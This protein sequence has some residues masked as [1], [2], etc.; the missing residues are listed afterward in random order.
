MSCLR[1]R[2][3]QGG[4]QSAAAGRIA[5]KEKGKDASAR[6]VPESPKPTNG[7][8]PDVTDRRRIARPGGATCQTQPEV[9]AR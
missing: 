1:R 8:S 4:D 2:S 9:S 7:V 6:V 5:E 3:E